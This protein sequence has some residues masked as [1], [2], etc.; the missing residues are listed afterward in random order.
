MLLGDALLAAPVCQ[1]G[2]RERDV[3]LPAGRWYDW[4]TG[5]AYDGP[6]DESVPAPLD[7]LPLF[8][9]G[10]TLVPLATLDDD[11]TV[12]DRSLTLR[13][14]PGDGAGSIYDDDG[15]TFDYRR[16]A[17]ALRRYRVRRR[18][19]RHGGQPGG[20]EGGFP[21]EAAPARVRVAGRRDDR[22]RRHRR[23]RRGHAAVGRRVSHRRTHQWPPSSVSGR[24]PRRTRS[25]IRCRCTPRRTSH[26]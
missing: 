16:G 3:Y 23:R 22:T 9:R 26:G 4:W 8:G 12:D 7:R 18:R 21:F 6:A 24:P 19:R 1:P 17:F 2:Q 11:G 10:G 5:A 14:F 13:V 15:E 25:M 20:I